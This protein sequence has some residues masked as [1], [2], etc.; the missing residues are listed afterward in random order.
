[1]AEAGKKS[2]QEQVQHLQKEVEMLQLELA[3]TSE[4]YDVQ[5]KRYSDR[6][7]KT[8]NKLQRA[9]SEYIVAC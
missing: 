5:L 8:K 1:M 9:R 7:L 4:K 3:A 6:K 2:L